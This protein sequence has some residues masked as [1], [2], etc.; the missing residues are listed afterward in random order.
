MLPGRAQL[1]RAEAVLVAT[2]GSAL[3]SRAKARDLALRFQAM[4]RGREG[5]TLATWIDAAMVSPLA[6]FAAGIRADR[7]AVAAAIVEPWS[8]GQTEGQI[9]KLKLVKPQMFGRAELDLLRARLVT[10]S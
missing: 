4:L 7:N 9:T 1:A 3:P 6:S 2:I 8:N 10:A 5:E